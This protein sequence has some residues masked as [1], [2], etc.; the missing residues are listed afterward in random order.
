MII[1]D[2]NSGGV[3]LDTVQYY[4][5]NAVMLSLRRFGSLRGWP[6]V[7]FS[8]PG[9]QLEAA[10]GK[11]ENWWSSMGDSLQ[12]LGSTKDFKWEISPPDSPWRQGKAERRAVIVKKLLKLSIGDSRLTPVELQTALMEVANMCIE[13]PIGLSK[14]RDDGTYSLIIPN[15]NQNILSQ[16]RQCFLSVTFTFGFGEL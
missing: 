9:S 6:G 7:I 5:A 16:Q 2:V 1:E 12:S 8:D 11:L 15:H 10:S 3:H 14:H 4:S 13:R